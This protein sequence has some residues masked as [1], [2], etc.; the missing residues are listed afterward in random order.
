MIPMTHTTNHYTTMTTEDWIESDTG[1]RDFLD[2]L[3]GESSDDLAEQVRIAV[4]GW[5]PLHRLATLETTRE[6]LHEL[7]PT[8]PAAVMLHGRFVEWWLG[9]DREHD[10]FHAWAVKTHGS[11][12]LCGTCWS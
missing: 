10:C 7:S 5:A 8:H 4:I 9:T 1:R 3:A 12:A 2:W 11:E 6:W